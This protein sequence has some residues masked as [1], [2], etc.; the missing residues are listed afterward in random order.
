MGQFVV[1]NLFLMGQ[2]VVV[3]LFYGKSV[4]VTLFYGTVCWG[5]PVFDRT[6]F[7]AILFPS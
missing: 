4:V 3:T 5:H 6:V 7:V 2:F 1:V